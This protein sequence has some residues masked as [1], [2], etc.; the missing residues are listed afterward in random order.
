MIQDLNIFTIKNFQNHKNVL[1]DL[2][3]KIP[4]TPLVSDGIDVEHSD[5]EVTPKMKREYIDYFKKHIF[6]DF[7]KEIC[8]NFNCD[9]LTLLNMWFQIY[10]KN[11]HHSI[12]RHGNAHFTNI[13]FLNLPNK[14]LVTKIYDLK[15]NPIDLRIEEGHILT[16]PAYLKH[17][18]S[19][20][21]SDEK[22][23]ILSY[24]ISIEN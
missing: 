2:I 23:I 1:I 5:W 4:Q 12:H 22:K 21:K 19:S 3:N 9:S 15:N 24:N 11:G 8:K 18:S 10:G 13:V 14:N 17:E 7:A 16:F 20:N 6:E